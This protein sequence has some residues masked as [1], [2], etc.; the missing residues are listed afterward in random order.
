MARVLVTGA[1]RGIGLATVLRLAAAGWD[2]IAGVRQAQDGERVAAL[3]SRVQA[4]LLPLTP[5]PVLDFVMKAASG[6][7]RKS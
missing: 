2:V 6:V 1:R 3:A 5:T 4:S 7:P